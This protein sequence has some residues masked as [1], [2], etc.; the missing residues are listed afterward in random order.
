MAV[1]NLGVIMVEVNDVLPG[2]LRDQF[3][4]ANHEVCDCGGLELRS[5]RGC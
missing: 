5:S 2:C 1:Q 3:H 4:D